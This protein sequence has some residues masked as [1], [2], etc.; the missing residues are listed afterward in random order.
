M[1]YLNNIFKNNIPLNFFIKLSP[2]QSCYIAKK[3][4]EKKIYVKLIGNMPD[5]T[6]R[7]VKFTSILSDNSKQFLI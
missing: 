1:K 2:K 4:V 3:P 7:F 5:I 6:Y